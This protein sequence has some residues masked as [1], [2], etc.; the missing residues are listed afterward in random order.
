MS[1]V[2]ETIDVNRTA[3][4]LLV[5]MPVAVTEAIVQTVMEFHAVV[6]L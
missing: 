3:T 4:M 2:K 1:A 5:R 6:R